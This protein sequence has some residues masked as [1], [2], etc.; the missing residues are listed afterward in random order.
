MNL[1]D[2][3]GLAKRNVL[4]AVVMMIAMISLAGVPPMVG[5]YAKLVVLKAA[6]GSD[7]CLACTC[8]C[9]H[10]GGGGVLLLAHHQADV[11]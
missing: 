8:W 4:L 1:S 3:A 11:L 6:V 10:V 7:L 5:F 9:R 2:L